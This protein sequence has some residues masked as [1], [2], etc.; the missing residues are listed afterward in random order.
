MKASNKGMTVTEKQTIIPQLNNADP[1][2]NF[3]KRSAQL[4]DEQGMPKKI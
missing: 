4:F 1:L 2:Y 3:Q